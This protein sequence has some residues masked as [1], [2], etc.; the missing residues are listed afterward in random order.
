ME[1]YLESRIDR[2]HEHA[3]FLSMSV[4]MAICIF[5]GFAPT[6]Y[7]KPWFPE[8]QQFAALRLS[9]AYRWLDI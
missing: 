9:R 4:S 8:A 1:T 2:R 3:F 6:F 7:L 5:V